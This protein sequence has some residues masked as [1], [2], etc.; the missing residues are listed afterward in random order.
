M[1]KLEGEEETYAAEN[2]LYRVSSQIGEGVEWKLLANGPFLEFRRTLREL[3]QK[4]NVE[5]RQF[6]WTQVGD[7]HSTYLTT[8]Y[9]N[10]FEVYQEETS[11]CMVSLILA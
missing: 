4:T 7:P 9:W 5:E 8:V 3:K 2:Y 11:Y 1:G 10:E 6:P